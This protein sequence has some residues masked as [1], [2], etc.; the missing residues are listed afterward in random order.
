MR[1]PELKSERNVDVTAMPEAKANPAI[2]PSRYAIS[3]S[4]AARV[5]F[6]V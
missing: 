6:P 3:D 2:P 5:G 1:S 4:S